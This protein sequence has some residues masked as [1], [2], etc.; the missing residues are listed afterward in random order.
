MIVVRIDVSE[1]TTEERASIE[2]AV[3]ALRAVDGVDVFFAG[4]DDALDSAKQKLLDIF[5][6]RKM[7]VG[8]V[9]NEKDLFQTTLRGD[10]DPREERAIIPALESLVEEGLLTYDERR[11]VHVLTESG[12][13]EVYRTDR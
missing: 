5:A 12:E 13:R 6:Q 4:Q 11:K 1:A 9:Y 8:H 2:P 10:F 7:A 3:E